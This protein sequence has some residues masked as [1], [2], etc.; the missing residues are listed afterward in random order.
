LF[1]FEENYTSTGRRLSEAGEARKLHQDTAYVNC[2]RLIRENIKNR[3]QRFTIGWWNGSS[4]RVP[5]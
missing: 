3:Q 1:I 5:A 2:L 4:G